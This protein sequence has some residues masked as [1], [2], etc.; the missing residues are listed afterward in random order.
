VGFCASLQQRRLHRIEPGA[1][2]YGPHHTVDEPNWVLARIGNVMY[3][4]ATGRSNL[5]RRSPPACSNDWEAGHSCRSTCRTH[6]A[7][8]YHRLWPPVL[9]RFRLLASPEMAYLNRL[10]SQVAVSLF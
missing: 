5:A 4:A 7:W 2:Q 3:L 9:N 10:D 1:R 6:C 8:G